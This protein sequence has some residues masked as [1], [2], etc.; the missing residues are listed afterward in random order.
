MRIFQYHPTTGEFMG[1]G[2]ADE[3]PLEPGVFAVP[4]HATELQPPEVGADFVAKFDGAAWAVEAIPA[5][6]PPPEPP[7]PTAES[8]RAERNARLTLCD[9]TQIPDAD[10]TTAERAAWK[11]YRKALRDIT[12]AKGFPDAVEWPSAPA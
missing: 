1:V 2:I 3:S 6:P 12:A 9:W 5:P 7:K 11:T 10:L 4:A 8:V